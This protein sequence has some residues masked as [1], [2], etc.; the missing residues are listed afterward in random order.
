MHSC[1]QETNG[2]PIQRA[3]ENDYKALHVIFGSFDGD[4]QKPS[5]AHTARLENELYYNMREARFMMT[6]SGWLG[7]VPLNTQ[8]GDGIYILA[9]GQMPFVLRRSNVTFSPQGSSDAGRLCYT[10]M[11]ECYLDQLMDGE[12]S[13][14]LRAAAV[15]IFIV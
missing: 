4:S 5:E 13:N 6:T 1:R 10:L 3:T 8:I 15:D 14:R 9:G 12:F 7:M 11:G 2:G